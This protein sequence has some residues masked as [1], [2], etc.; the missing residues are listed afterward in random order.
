MVNKCNWYSTAYLQNVK[1][2]KLIILIGILSYYMPTSHC[3]SWPQRPQE[4]RNPRFGLRKGHGGPFWPHGGLEAGPRRL[5][6]RQGGLILAVSRLIGYPIPDKPF[7]NK[8]EFHDVSGKVQ[9]LRYND[10][11]QKEIML[12]CKPSE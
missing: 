8:I 9:N 2:F 7:W 4:T 1:C 11:Q 10:L 5:Q 6:K 12:M 3:A